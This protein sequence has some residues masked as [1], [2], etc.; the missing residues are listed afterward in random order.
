MRK[1]VWFILGAV[2]LGSLFWPWLL[3]FGACIVIVAV[4]G[5]ITNRK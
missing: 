2:F 3:F 5:M 4:V 1:G